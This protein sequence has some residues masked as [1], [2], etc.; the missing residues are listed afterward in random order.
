M[1]PSESSLRSRGMTCEMPHSEFIMPFLRSCQ[2]VKPKSTLRPSFGFS[3]SP[4]VFCA[5]SSP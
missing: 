4:A 3:A 1:R 5:Y 2:P